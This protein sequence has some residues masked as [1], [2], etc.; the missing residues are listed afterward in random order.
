[1]FYMYRSMAEILRF[2]PIQPFIF[3][4]HSLEGNELFY[5]SDIYKKMSHKRN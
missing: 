4:L 3:P 2:H 1:M 5:I